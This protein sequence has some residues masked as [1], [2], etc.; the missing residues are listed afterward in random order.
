MV[1][2]LALLK[3]KIWVPSLGSSICP[4]EPSH[5]RLL[6][7]HP[8]SISTG[9][10]P[11]SAFFFHSYPVH[12]NSRLQPLEQTIPLFPHKVL[13]TDRVEFFFLL[14][15]ILCLSDGLEVADVF[16]FRTVLESSRSVFRSLRS[17]LIPFEQIGPPLTLLAILWVCGFSPLRRCRSCVTSCLPWMSVERQHLSFILIT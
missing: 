7:R 16:F 1:T 11:Y 14:L 15:A 2:G 17:M 12:E 5:S 4:P 6:T 3:V 13:T 9:V 10:A 8:V